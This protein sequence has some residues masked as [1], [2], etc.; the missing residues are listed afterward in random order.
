MNSQKLHQNL[1][2]KRHSLLR[3]GYLWSIS[4]EK[5]VCFKIQNSI[6]IGDRCRWFFL[7]WFKLWCKVNVW[8]QWVIAIKV[9]IN[10]FLCYWNKHWYWWIDKSIANEQLGTLI[11]IKR[12]TWKHDFSYKSIIFGRFMSFAWAFFISYRFPWC[13][14]LDIGISNL[15]I[16]DRNSFFPERE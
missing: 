5:E 8:F 13:S 9:F 3:E 16:E 1:I 2:F 7:S 4:S 14:A 6:E 10:L 11:T 15:F 12:I